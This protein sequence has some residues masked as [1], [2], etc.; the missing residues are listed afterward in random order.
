VAGDYAYVAD[1]QGD[2]QVID[3]S[4]PT[5]PTIAGALI[6]PQSAWGLALDDDHL[7]VAGP[8]GLQIAW[9]QCAGD[10]A[11]L[12]T[13]FEI[14]R[15]PAAIAIRWSSSASAP[16]SE[17]RLRGDQDGRTW[18]LPYTDVGGGVYTATQTLPGDLVDGPVTYFLSYRSRGQD[19]LLLDR[20]TVDLDLVPRGARLL[21]SHPNP[22]NPRSR[23]AFSID[24]GQHVAVAIYD[25]WGKLVRELTAAVYLAGEHEL[26]WDGTDT[27]GHPAPSGTYVVRLATQGHIESRKLMLVR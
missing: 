25:V 10:V 16:G 2:V 19:W 17:F 7:Y 11:V 27:G 9:K 23:I 14:R 24:Q 12:L 8:A 15:E 3:V 21:G 22:F 4:V 6:V 20:R 26:A 18:D 13:S 1:D 5:S